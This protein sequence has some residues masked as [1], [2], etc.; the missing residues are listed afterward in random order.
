MARIEAFRAAL[1]EPL[2]GAVITERHNVRWLSGFSG[3]N[4][5]LVVPASGTPVLVTDGRYVD[6]A[7][8]ESPGFEVVKSRDLLGG[9]GGR[10]GAGAWAV[11]THD[12]TVDAHKALLAATEQVALEPLGRVIEELRITKDDAEIDAL[13]RA[14][15]IS[16][17]SL[18][19]L[20]DQPLAGLTERQVAHRLENLMVERGAEGVAFETIVA[21]GENSAIPHHAP[22]DRELR[23]GDLLKIDFGARVDGY[24]ADC[25]RT[26]VIGPADDFQREIHGAVRSAQAAG[27]AALADGAELSAAW[28]ASTEVL[29]QAGWLEQFTTGLG[30]GVGLAIHEDPY[31]S[32]R[33]TGKL[34]ARTVLTIE[35]GIY[36]P[37]RGGVRIEDTV[38]VTRELPEIL[39]PWTTELLEIA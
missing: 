24:H 19:A 21:A 36:V 6:Q 25:T 1:P 39:T 35:P 2:A 27:V 11:E 37:G 22:T 13:R 8:A 15:A 7:E 20:I 17:E 3:S 31:P 26:F 10:L 32:Q 23:R 28:K 9:V 29:E 12:L 33:A 16:V 14:C 30:H 38:L 5:A 34:A 4:G 18:T